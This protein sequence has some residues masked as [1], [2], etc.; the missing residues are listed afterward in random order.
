LIPCQLLTGS[1]RCKVGHRMMLDGK[2][3]LGPQERL[4]KPR[5][6]LRAT[7]AALVRGL[8][9]HPPYIAPKPQGGAVLLFLGA[10]DV[11]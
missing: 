1:S 5:V 4:I 8:A 7:L 3:V 6:V 11:S 9:R 10:A 2:F